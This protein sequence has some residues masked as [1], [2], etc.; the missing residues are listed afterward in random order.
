MT[1][2]NAKV[3]LDG[4]DIQVDTNGVTPYSI[5]TIDDGQ[6][7]LSRE[8]ISGVRSDDGSI[9][10]DVQTLSGKRVRVSYST[11]AAPALPENNLENKDLIYR[12]FLEYSYQLRGSGMPRYDMQHYYSKYY[13][14]QQFWAKR[15]LLLAQLNDPDI[16]KSGRVTLIASLDTVY[17]GLAALSMPLVMFGNTFQVVFPEGNSCQFSDWVIGDYTDFTFNLI[18]RTIIT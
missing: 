10:F 9:G 16:P 18:H 11:A 2:R 12:R 17:A 6:S 15:Q 1:I 13:Q 3:S 14:A 8:R 7:W 5:T 4:I